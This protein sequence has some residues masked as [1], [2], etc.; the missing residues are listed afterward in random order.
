VSY[1]VTVKKLSLTNLTAEN[2]RIH[3]NLTFAL[4]A[5]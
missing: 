2:N 3:A 1:E 4:S 5:K